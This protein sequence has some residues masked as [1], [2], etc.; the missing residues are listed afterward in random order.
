MKRKVGKKLGLSKETLRSLDEMNLQGVVGGLTNG[1]NPCS[2]CPICN[3]AN[4]T[5]LM[6]TDGVCCA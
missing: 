4:Q 1:T 5:C 2:A 3:S 6:N